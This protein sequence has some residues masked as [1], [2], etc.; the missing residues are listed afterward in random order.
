M[1]P[2]FILIIFTVL[3]FF[4]VSLVLFDHLQS[5]ARV[6]N[7]L[8]VFTSVAVLVLAP[9]S[10][11]ASARHTF[12]LRFKASQAASVWDGI[13]QET[14]L[15]RSNGARDLVVPSM[16]VSEWELGWGRSDLLPG[17]DPKAPTNR[18]LAEY[19]E[20]DTITFK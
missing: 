12:G 14:R 17:G 2:K 18:C 4:T 16:N 9:L 19:Y 15:S 11:L 6:R 3:W 5:S 7:A 20:L 8:L 1:I 13:D 10:P